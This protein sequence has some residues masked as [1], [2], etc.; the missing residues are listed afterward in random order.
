MSDEQHALAVMVTG[1]VGEQIARAGDDV[2]V[3]LTFRP[4][5]LDVSRTLAFECL[6]WHAVEPA[7]VALAQSRVDAHRDVASVERDAHRLERSLEIR[8]VYDRDAVVA[9]TLTN[10]ARA[11]TAGL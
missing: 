8:Y 2:E 4:G 3:A 11:G 6:A 5:D 10:L 7:V 9:P 1:N